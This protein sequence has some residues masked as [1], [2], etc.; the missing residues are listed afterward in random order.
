MSAAPQQLS[1]DPKIAARQQW[2]AARDAEMA[3][4]APVATVAPADDPVPEPEAELVLHD[5]HVTAYH[6]HLKLVKEAHVEPI[7]AKAET[8]T[9]EV[10]IIPKPAPAQES[11]PQPTPDQLIGAELLDSVHA[12]LSRFVA[13]PSDAEHV[14]HTLWIAHTHAMDAWESTPRIAFLS[15]EPGSGKTRA[16]ELTET[17]V[18]R[19][20]ESI[21]ATPAYLFRKVSDPE[22]TPTILYDEIDT[23][24]GPK[25][26]DNEEVRGILNAGHRRGAVA[27]RCVV[28]GK[29]IETEELPAYCAVAMAGL[30]GLPDTILSRS[31]VVRMRR[32]L[33]TETVEPY[34]RRE[35]APEGNAIRDKLTA[36]A[37]SV[38]PAM[39]A[40]W[41]AMPAGVEDRNADVWEALLAVADAAGGTWPERARVSS[42]SLVSL[43]MVATPSL[44]IR[45]LSDLQTIFGDHSA[46]ATGDILNALIDLQESPWGDLKGKPINARRLANYLKPYGV[47]SKQ[48]RIGSSTLK[49]YASEDLHDPWERYL[50]TA[51]P[52][53]GL[54]ALG[55]ETWET[56]ET[57]TCQ[58]CLGEGC[59]W[60]R[61]DN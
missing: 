14:A 23:L 32:R 53:L 19:P 38:A 8:V 17:L 20:V 28:R 27:G 7:A 3:S 50:S 49:G 12:Y 35:H 9:P 21:N 31:V 30:G 54:P 42:V 26:K 43:S 40:A 56:S 47:S 15:P 25:A 57:Q 29:I 60:C 2:K 39:R 37:A 58:K 13:Y 41:P 61:R 4:A 59:A 11:G 45:L 6:A 1:R 44:G 52:P 36:W 24:F 5:V 48:V 18:P 55:K 10:N 34:R 33:S 16:L 22:G 51:L 46:L